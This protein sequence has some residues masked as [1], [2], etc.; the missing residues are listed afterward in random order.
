MSWRSL[1][2]LKHDSHPDHELGALKGSTGSV[3]SAH[4]YAFSCSLN[5]CRTDKHT[6]LFIYL[7]VPCGHG[8]SVPDQAARALAVS[9][10]SMES[11]FTGSWKVSVFLK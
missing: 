9:S 1:V 11:L 2:S 4:Y 3:C 7:Q 5:E 8:S 6:I 10:E